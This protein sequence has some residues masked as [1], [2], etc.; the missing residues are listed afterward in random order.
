MIEHV[1]KTPVLGESFLWSWHRAGYLE[2]GRLSGWY[3]IQ[4]FHDQSNTELRASRI[5]LIHDWTVN[6]VPSPKSQR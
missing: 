3:A 2:W 6:G 5:G 4:P 1:D